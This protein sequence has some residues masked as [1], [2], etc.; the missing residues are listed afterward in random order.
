M[1]SYK[2]FSLILGTTLSLCLFPFN[3]NA[4]SFSANAQAR[5]SIAN[6]PIPKDSIKQI[7]NPLIPQCTKSR[8]GNA[9]VECKDFQESLNLAQGVI[10]LR[11]GLVKGTANPDGA[12]KAEAKI[13]SSRINYGNLDLNPDFSLDYSASII[14]EAN[15]EDM[16]SAK[17]FYSISV[18]ALYQGKNEENKTINELFNP[19]GT[20]TIQPLTALVDAP[21][22][23]FLVIGSS[24]QFS[25]PSSRISKDQEELTF[26]YLTV[27]ITIQGEAQA[28]KVFI[29]EYNSNL[30]LAIL[31]FLGSIV[32]IKKHI[33]LRS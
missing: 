8:S 26:Q 22:D 5:L 19:I 27:G 21:Q 31:V 18:R 33:K 17:A 14:A 12:S 32:T 29:P 2:N 4:A 24:V 16:E 7:R 1:F 3:A 13:I 25:L 30:S 10:A 28:G 23:D 9:T 15:N 11:T 6:A 20:S